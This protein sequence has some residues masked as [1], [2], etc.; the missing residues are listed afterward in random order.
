[1]LDALPG[2]GRDI[3]DE[4]KLDALRLRRCARRG[5]HPDATADELDLD[6]G[7]L[8]WGTYGDDYFPAVF[9][10]TR[11]LAGAKVFNAPAVGVHAGR[12]APTAASPANPV[13]RGLADL[14]ARTAGP[15]DPSAR[16]QFRKAIED[17][18]DELAVGAGQP[19]PEP[20]PGP[21]RL[22]GDAPR[23]PSAR[24]SP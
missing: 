7:W 11:D 3:W 6:L 5:I 1:M 16:R 2:S 21:G 23:R 22:H 17:M 10:R 18:T 15:D 4:H 24:T 9:G 14:W 13:E 19:D 8:A 20:H 12:R